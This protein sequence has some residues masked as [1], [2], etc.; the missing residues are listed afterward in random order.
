VTILDEVV[1]IVEFVA[2]DD[3][4]ILRTVT[5]DGYLVI[6]ADDA[7]LAVSGAIRHISDLL[8]DCSLK[9]LHARHIGDVALSLR[10]L[11]GAIGEFHQL[12]H[13][14][15]A[16]ASDLMLALHRLRDAH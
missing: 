9:A 13:L 14:L 11:I 4:R 6:E 1:I 15:G 5:V 3:L 16:I 12:L 8:V 2:G 7:E 10:E